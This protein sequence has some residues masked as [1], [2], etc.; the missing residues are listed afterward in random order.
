MAETD[1]LTNDPEAIE[2][3]LMSKVEASE[4]IRQEIKKHE[5]KILLAVRSSRS[6]IA[7]LDHLFDSVLQMLRTTAGLSP[8]HFLDLVHEA[9]DEL[10]HGFG[11]HPVRAEPF[12]F[13]PERTAGFQI[14]YLRPI[15]RELL[16]EIEGGQPVTLATTTDVR[17]FGQA[18]IQHELEGRQQHEECRRIFTWTVASG[19]FEVARKDG[20]IV[21]HPAGSPQLYSP[22]V[23][24]ILLSALCEEQGKARDE[25]WLGAMIDADGVGSFEHDSHT[26]KMLTKFGGRDT[27]SPQA[28]IILDD[29]DD[30]GSTIDLP[31]G[32]LLHLQMHHLKQLIE[33]AEKRDGWSGNA[34]KVDSAFASL[35]SFIMARQTEGALF[36]VYDGDIYLNQ[37]EISSVANINA[38][39]LRDASVRLRR[40]G[41]GTQILVFS[42][43][44][45][46]PSALSGEVLHID[47]PLPSKLELLDDI[48]ARAERILTKERGLASGHELQVTDGLLN[49]VDAAAGMTLNEMAHAIRQ[50]LAGGADTSADLVQALNL[51]KRTAIRKSAALELL[52]RDPPRELMLGGMETFWQWLSIRHRVFKH[53]ELASQ[54]GIDRRP[55]GVLLLGIPGTGKSLAAKIIAREWQVPLVRLDMG[56]LQ[57]RWVGASEERIREA[58]Q[59]VQA[60]SPCIL[61]IDEI[62]KGIA[63]GEGTA[64]HSTDLNIRATLLTWLQ[65]HDSAVFVVATANRFANLPPELTRAGRFD[66]RFF[67]GCPDEE[68]RLEILKIH[69]DLRRVSMPD[70]DK[71]KRIAAAMQGFTGAE[72]EQAV[73]DGLYDAFSADR[74]PTIEDFLSAVGR[75]KPIIRAA[76]RGLEEVWALIEQGR[77]ELASSRFL[78]KT[79]VAKLVDPEMFSPMYCRLE[80]IGGWENHAGRA[81]RLLMRDQLGLPAAVVLETGDP[82]WA[83]VQTNVKMD[84]KDPCPFKFVDMLSEIETNGVFDRLIVECGLETIWFETAGVMARFKD[85][86]MLSAY[87]ELFRAIQEDAVQ[88]EAA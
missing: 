7:Q 82:D 49:I 83:Y 52:D 64:S 35:M 56:A 72:I 53:P 45:T 47:L 24:I 43:P 18:I 41:K 42:G 80:Q 88:Q 32:L 66:A 69:L 75:T 12:E 14:F 62:D 36:I 81:T 19:L 46:P 11:Y 4:M 77:V 85:R 71:L 68:G 63:Q 54:F 39:F 29:L 17:R 59:I 51:A 38:A 76:S 33:T 73:L 55:K 67:F 74:L 79:D 37:A 84:L 50:A 21:H 27:L 60:M 87:S 9:L 2:A 40:E 31:G 15:E 65:E 6:P 25:V 23:N 1:D 8:E 34:G 5:Q 70:R 86:P 10:L 48:R 22:D 58:L 61:W 26:I 20:R 13:G 78:T 30:E 16:N 44:V 57:N 3:L 28:E